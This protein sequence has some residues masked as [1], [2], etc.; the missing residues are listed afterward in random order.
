VSR[1]LALISL[2]SVVGC[3]AFA[4]DKAALSV[5]S[6]VSP[7]VI[8]NVQ[9]SNSQQLYQ[10]YK[11]LTGGE[12]YSTPL[13]GTADFK[14][15]SKLLLETGDLTQLTAPS[16]S[17][18]VSV[19]GDFCARLT[20]VESPFRAKV[21]SGIAFSEIAG[22]PALS[23]KKLDELIGNLS[24]Q[25]WSRSI[26]SDERDLVRSSFRD[27]Y[28]NVASSESTNT[29][30]KASALFLCTAYLGSLQAVER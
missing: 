30:N 10:T 15:M 21:F 12:P 28:P 1:Y 25:L 24:I 9:V 14:S 2:L 4:P 22:T 7:E 23:A 11:S 18:I 29:L 17:A 26:A 3:S 20:Q 8:H 16:W 13:T 6:F 5:S 27:I 19:A